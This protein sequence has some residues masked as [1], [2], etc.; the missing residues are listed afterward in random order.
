MHADTGTGVATHQVHQ[1][2]AQTEASRAQ[3][4]QDEAGYAHDDQ[5]LVHGLDGLP[6]RRLADRLV[7]DR[8]R[9]VGK[10]DKRHQ[11][12]HGDGD[13]V[14]IRILREA[15]DRHVRR[16]CYCYYIRGWGLKGIFYQ[17]FFVRADL[18]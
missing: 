2:G 7:Q 13:C 10:K 18:S 14:T 6:E 9:V 16:H 15:E 5:L 1:R 4:R 12:R 11:Y 17:P 8:E 3:Q